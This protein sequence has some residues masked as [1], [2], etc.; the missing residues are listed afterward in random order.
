[1]LLGSVAL[2]QQPQTTAPVS[3]LNAKYVGG[4]GNGY[5]STAG[6]GLVLNIS[7]GTANCSST[8]VSY[9]GGT[10]TLTLSTTNYVY[11]NTAASCVPAFNTTGFT[12]TMIPLATVVTGASAITTITDN[13]TMQF[14][15]G[16]GTGG[17]LPK[18]VID[19]TSSTYNILPGYQ[20]Y[21]AAIASGSPNV[22]STNF[23]FTSSMIGW[24]A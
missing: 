16:T 20:I 7:A 3:D 10:L 23:N 13:R 17:G 6:A 4:M 21:D 15:S 22:T 14:A 24:F 11:L 2:A 5:Q 19:V 1:M 12:S 18:Q 8:I 9:A